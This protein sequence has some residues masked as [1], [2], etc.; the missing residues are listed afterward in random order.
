MATTNRDEKMKEITDRLQAGLEELFNSEKYAEYLRVMS[1]F[2]H[3]S[4]N[5]TLLIAMQKP[6]ATLVANVIK[7][8]AMTEGGKARRNE[9]IGD[10]VLVFLKNGMAKRQT[11]VCQKNTIQTK[12]IMLLC[13]GS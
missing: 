4:F 10:G 2:H 7:I 6:D 13:K 3:Y 5:N 11:T 8:K 9:H 12:K 1:Q